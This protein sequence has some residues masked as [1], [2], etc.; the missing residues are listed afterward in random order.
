MAEE[1]GAVV[2]TP[3]VGPVAAVRTPVVDPTRLLGLAAELAVLA[4]AAVLDKEPA[5]A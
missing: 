4:T 2:E 1:T 5:R 3:A